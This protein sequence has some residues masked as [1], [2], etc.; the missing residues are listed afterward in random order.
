M[1]GILLAVAL[2]IVPWPKEV[3]E[4]FGCCTNEAVEYR[5]DRS[6]PPE[7]YALEVRRDAVKV[8]SAGEPKLLKD[9]IAGIAPGQSAVFYD[10]DVV[11]GGG[12]I[13]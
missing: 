5:E 11:V 8:R 10:G 3:V 13:V 9:G 7:G 6:L 4:Q 12:I 2:N 1:N